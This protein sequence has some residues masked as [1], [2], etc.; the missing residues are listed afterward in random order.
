VLGAAAHAVGLLDAP[1]GVEI[2]ELADVVG[3][4]T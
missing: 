4:R 2:G 3:R 1:R